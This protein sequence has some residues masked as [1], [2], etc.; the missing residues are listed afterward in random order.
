MIAQIHHDIATIFEDLWLNIDFKK[1]IPQWSEFEGQIKGLA[2]SYS[3]VNK[4]LSRLAL[5]FG[6]D[7]SNQSTIDI[8]NKYSDEEMMDIIR[9]ETP[10]LVL[11]LKLRREKNK[12][13]Y[14]NWLDQKQEHPNMSFSQAQKELPKLF[15]D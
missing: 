1:H 3:N 14:Q 8:I 15:Q 12:E 10:I 13:N 5:R 2:N 11:L 7:Y 9:T 4:Y 6:S